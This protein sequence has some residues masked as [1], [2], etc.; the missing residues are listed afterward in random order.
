[1]ECAIAAS[2]KSA[3]GCSVHVMANF[4]HSAKTSYLRGTVPV[5]RANSRKTGISPRGLGMDTHQLRLAHQLSAKH[6]LKLCNCLSEATSQGLR[7]WVRGKPEFSLQKPRENVRCSTT[8]LLQHFYGRWDIET[9][10]NPEVHGS[11][12]QAY[13][14]QNQRSHQ[15]VKS[16][17]LEYWSLSPTTVH[18]L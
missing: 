5:F 3:P 10:E 12:S 14:A 1:M 17:D 7:A 4:S 16:K 9:G 2:K 15:K 13:T 8:H 18:A 11:A 6:N